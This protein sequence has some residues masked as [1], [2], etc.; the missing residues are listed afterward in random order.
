MK[1]L[2][3]M[4]TYHGDHKYSQLTDKPITIQ[5]K[6]PPRLFV[7]LDKLILRSIK[8]VKNQEQTKRCT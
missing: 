2:N 8:E 5:V 4:E 7:G 6:F 1:D 3:K